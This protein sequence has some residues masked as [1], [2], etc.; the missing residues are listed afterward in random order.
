MNI[1]IQTGAKKVHHH[2]R[3]DLGNPDIGGEAGRTEGE[4]LNDQQDL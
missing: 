2:Q 4:C 3:S 1:D